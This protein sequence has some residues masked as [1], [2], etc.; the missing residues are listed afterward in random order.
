MLLTFGLFETAADVCSTLDDLSNAGFAP[1]S[2]SLAARD[3]EGDRGE[4]SDRRMTIAQVL[5]ALELTPAATR[6]DTLAL[7]VIPEE[8]T[9]LTA[10]RLAREV[11]RLSVDNQARQSQLERFLMVLG[12]AGEE[13]TFLGG[14]L[15]AGSLFVGVEDGDEK[16]LAAARDIFTEQQAIHVGDA[17]MPEIDGPD[18]A[19]DIPLP[20][21]CVISDAV[22]LDV[23]NLRVLNGDKSNS[24]NE[25]LGRQLVDE[26]GA[27]IGPIT[28][29]VV[30]PH[31]IG[32][33]APAYIVVQHGGFL[34]VG[35]QEY[36][37]P[38]EL[39][40]DA[41]GTGGFRARLELDVLENAPAFDAR[42][43]ISRREEMSICGYYGTV[44]YWES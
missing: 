8:G 29:I 18:G 16:R 5:D 24:R 23:S 32:Y 10:G 26:A 43:P 22:V 35:R 39:I 14:R 44:P 21:A 7:I 38:I 33:G 37:I 11:A 41:P 19:S 30:D 1:N 36:V 6:L 20:D 13:A 31:V 28:G 15:Q 27:E 2:F 25:M 17:A 42:L 4:Q 9:F 3:V 40:H 34:G 12:C